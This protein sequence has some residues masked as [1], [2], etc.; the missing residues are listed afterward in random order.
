MIEIHTDNPHDLVRKINNAIDEKRIVT[1]IYDEDEDYIHN[2]KQWIGKAWITPVYDKHD[3]SLL[4]F[5]IVEPKT[6]KMSR[7]TYAVY[8]GRFLEMLLTYFDRDIIS[9]SVSPMLTPY[10]YFDSSL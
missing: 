7:S 8:H 2:R 9:V 1:W 3:A 10:D 6:Q 4:R 5:C